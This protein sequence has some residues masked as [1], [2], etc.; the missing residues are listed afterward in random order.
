[1]EILLNSAEGLSAKKIFD[2]FPC[3][4]KRKL[5]QNF[6]FDE[7]IN[8]RIVSVAGDLTGKTIVEIGSG[9]GGL[10]LEI[11]RHPIKKVYVVEFDRHWSGV[12]RNLSQLFG[13]KLEVVEQDA[14]KFD[15]RSIAPNVVISNLPYNISTQLL[16]KLLKEFDC[17][18]SLV[19]M[20]QKEVADRLYAVPS[21]KSYGRLSVLSQWKSRVEKAFD[22][23]PGSFFPPPKIKSTVVKFTPYHENQ[24]FDNFN[25]F[26]DLLTAAFAH[27]RKNVHKSLSKFCVNAKQILQ[28]LGYDA[29]TRA[30]EI[31]VEN[32]IRFM[33]IFDETHT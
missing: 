12:W 21:T 27:R 5:G 13:E 18:G 28:E 8:R 24:S 2:A 33:R 17:Y 25:L 29:N 23:E 3:G 15:F 4:I 11:L 26:S 10:T 30:E 1:M 20:F 31:T 14:L 6:L 22:L 32:Y 16:L 9:P 19:L 7:K